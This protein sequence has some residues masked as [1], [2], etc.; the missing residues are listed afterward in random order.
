[1]RRGLRLFN[2]AQIKNSQ[3]QRS[4]LEHVTKWIDKIKLSK[5]AGNDFD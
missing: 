1:M 3:T 5:F 2:W 4:S